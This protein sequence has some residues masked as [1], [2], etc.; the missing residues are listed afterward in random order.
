MPFVKGRSGNPSG[1]PK[2]DPEVKQLART[3]STEAIKRLV[4]WM[5]DDNPKASVTACLALL[6][7]AFGKP[8][9]SLDISGD[10]T[11]RHV[12]EYATHELVAMLEQT[13]DPRRIAAKKARPGDGREVH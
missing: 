1:R 6:D 12:R 7:R 4:A 11:S 2:E 13:T 5:R 8:A 9:Q 10:I 3:Y